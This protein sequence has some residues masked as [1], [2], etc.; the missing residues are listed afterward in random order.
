HH[1]HYYCRLPPSNNTTTITTTTTTS[2]VSSFINLPPPPLPSVPGHNPINTTS[3][4][5]SRM[6]VGMKYSNKIKMEADPS[7]SDVDFSEYMWMGDEGV[8][9]FDRQVEKE[10]LEE[11]LKEGQWWLFSPGK[12]KVPEAEITPAPLTEDELEWSRLEEAYEEMLNEG[13]QSSSVSRN[14]TQRFNDIHL[15]TPVVK[16]LVAKS[17]LNPNAPEFVPSAGFQRS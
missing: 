3:Q 4:F 5:S 15:S 16:E 11:M 9:N 8:E 7:Q 10:F 17:Q 1:H 13:V 6:S 2:T 12:S 14:I